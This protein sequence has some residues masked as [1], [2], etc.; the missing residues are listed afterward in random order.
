MASIKQVLFTIQED[1]ASTAGSVQAEK[2]IELEQH[3]AEE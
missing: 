3:K 2:G 1:E